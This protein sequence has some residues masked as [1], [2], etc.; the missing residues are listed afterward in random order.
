MRESAFQAILQE[1]AKYLLAKSSLWDVLIGFSS[2][3]FHPTQSY[4]Y[5]CCCYC[6]QMRG[7]VFIIALGIMAIN[8]ARPMHRMLKPGYG[9]GAFSERNKAV[10]GLYI[11]G[12]RMLATEL[13]LEMQP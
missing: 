5:Y 1:V 6:L 2:L 11:K 8:Q 3:A 4:I 10:R 7:I 12:E 13:I 9:K